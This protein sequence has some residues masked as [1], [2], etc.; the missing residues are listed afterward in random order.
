M[1]KFNKDTACC[2]GIVKA[3]GFQKIFANQYVA[4]LLFSIAAM[5]QNA[6]ANGFPA[7]IYRYLE[8]RFNM[9]SVETGALASCYEIADVLFSLFL[10]HI[11]QKYHKPRV[12]AC[13]LI[14]A[15]IGGIIFIL[16]HYINDKYA[17]SGAG[18]GVILPCPAGVDGLCAD[19]TITGMLMRKGVGCFYAGM[20]IIGAS[21]VPMHAF[22]PVWID[23]NVKKENV[24]TFQA[25]WIC[26][27]IIG[28]T[29]GAIGGGELAVIHTDFDRLPVLTPP[30]L[31]PL[32]PVWVGAWWP[33]IFGASCALIFTCFFVMMI[34]RYLQNDHNEEGVQDQKA[35][36]VPYWASTKELFSNP[37]WWLCTLCVACDSWCVQTMQAFG[38]RQMS[39]WFRLSLP[40]AAKWGGGLFLTGTVLG[41]ITIG[42]VMKKLGGDKM[43]ISTLGKLAR[44]GCMLGFCASFA[45]LL[46]FSDTIIE[47]VDNTQRGNR[48]DNSGTNSLIASTVQNCQ[49]PG[50]SDNQ[51]SNGENMTHNTW[52]MPVCGTRINQSTV[53][54]NNVVNNFGDCLTG[55]FFP[56]CDLENGQTYYSPC[57]GGCDVFKTVNGVL[58][59]NAAEAAVFTEMN[60]DGVTVDRFASC[61]CNKE[62]G[63]PFTGAASGVF[64]GVGKTTTV[65]G[66]CA[67]NPAG[68]DKD[69]WLALH[70]HLDTNETWKF[71]LFWAISVISIACFYFSFIPY[72]NIWIQGV[73]FENRSQSMAWSS[74]FVRVIGGIPGPI[75]V[76]Y[77]LDTT[78]IIWE[79]N[80]CGERGTCMVF[81]ESSAFVMLGILLVTRFLNMLFCTGIIILSE[82]KEAEEARVPATN[83]A[84]EK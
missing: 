17:L 57:F 50:Y 5:F 20:L 6:C 74:I 34:P 46:R 65:P 80:V 52:V 32:A 12:V 28:A 56:V 41:N 36:K 45:Y 7:S 25:F 13:G 26:M 24:G 15:G 19:S 82:R 61:S 40:M 14:F 51:W 18:A 79:K 58:S 84:F 76:G 9:N 44:G 78:C 73:R 42:I 49:R 39:L 60:V 10:I 4:V 35:E 2:G 55:T 64:S 16:P 68:I 33:G 43:K 48:F 22:V 30:Q 54:M 1:S 27:A 53:A 81:S 11:F 83:E 23:E 77:I 71:P 63:H 37:I 62:V 59:G 21:S 70:P 3:E 75:L 8:V 72:M 38:V 29:V 69:V 31:N 66:F 47:G 67:D